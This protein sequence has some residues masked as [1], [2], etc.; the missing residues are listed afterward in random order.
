M[1]YTGVLEF[2]AAKK[3]SKTML[4]ACYYEGA[5]KLTRPVYHETN[6]PSVYLIHIG[7]GY[8]DGDTYCTRINV[9]EGAEI[10]VTTQASTKV[11]KTP[12]APVVQKMAMTVNEGAVLEYMPDPLI[13][14]EGARFMQETT[15]HLKDDSCFLYSDMITPG[16]A[17]DGSL[18]RYDWIRSKLKVYRSGKLVVFDHLLLEPDDDIAGIM[19]MEGYTH[20]GTFFIFHQQAGKPFLEGLYKS[21]EEFHFEARFGLSALPESGLILRILAHR[22]GIIEKMIAHV[23]TYTRRTLLGKDRVDWRK[24]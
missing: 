5:L 23:H 20:V 17:P 9:E 21:L 24:Y 18:F 2:S 6:S 11:Y 16:W 1:S 22:T 10:A 14:Y 8:V 19:Q 15:V 3:H 13:V 12:K 4:A 7:G